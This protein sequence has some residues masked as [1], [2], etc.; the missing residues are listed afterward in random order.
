MKKL[1]FYILIFITTL[2]FSNNNYGQIVSNNIKGFCVDDENYPVPDISIYKS[3]DIL[4]AATDKNGAFVLYSAQIGDTLYFSHL[5]FEESF[6][7]VKEEDFI[8]PLKIVMKMNVF[9]LPDVEIIANAPHVAYDNKVVSIVDYEI[10]EKGVYLIAWRQKGY[11]LLHLSFKMDTLSEI[12]ISKK[13][14][15]L[16]K[17]VFE[18]IHLI[19]SN[20]CYQIGH[21]DFR[22]RLGKMELM[23]GMTTQAFLD[24]MGSTAAATDSIIATGNYFFYNKE[25]YYYS[26]KK[27]G[28]NNTPKIIRHIVDEVGRDD[29]ICILKTGGAPRNYNELFTKPIYNPMFEADNVLYIFSFTENKTIKYDINGDFIAEY[30][31][32]LHTYEHWNGKLRV[33][34]DWK[35]K[36]L[37]DPAMTDFYALFEKNG[38]T[39]MKE[40]DIETGLSRRD[41]KIG[42][43]PFIQNL[44]VYDGNAYFLYSDD[45]DGHRKKLYRVRLK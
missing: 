21:K 6:H 2:L 12:K 13:Y 8:N 9:E 20:F 10:N 41:F 43:Y 5:A 23:Y 42:G 19:S 1:L 36:V 14:D 29:I 31:L 15:N 22:N 26:H 38:V 18:E 17:D 35:N 27:E 40:I 24:I 30:P 34:K 28:N 11:S 37:M 16:Y 39:I 33:H 45:K 32:T 25:L 3:G 44:R 4:M 7:V